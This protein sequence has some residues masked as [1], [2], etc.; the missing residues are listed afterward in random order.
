MVDLVTPGKIEQES[1]DNANAGSDRVSISSKRSASEV[2]TGI[3]CHS[4]LNCEIFP[5]M[6][7][8][9]TTLSSARTV[10]TSLRDETPHEAYK[11]H[12]IRGYHAQ[13]D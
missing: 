12:P 4:L 11:T 5:G 6:A 9:D 3:R 1:P 8:G 13:Y 7:S 10:F 2:A